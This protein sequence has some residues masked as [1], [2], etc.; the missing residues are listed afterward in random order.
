LSD[1][2]P[3]PAD[4]RLVYGPEPLQFGDVRR[5]GGDGPHALVIVLHGGAWKSTFNL[6]HAGHM[7][8]ALRDEGFAPFNV[9]DRRVGD[10]GGGWPGTFQDVLAAVDF[11]L[12]LPGIDRD[13]V[14]I[15]GHSA[16]GHLCILA[17]AELRLPVLP[18]A[19]G[20]DI[21][22]WKSEASYAF[23]SEDD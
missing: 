23:V 6:I 1:A 7:C 3:P 12:E 15:A 21:E 14:A 22:A 9:E 10:V 4:E 20:S 13:R 19:A 18:M 16:G 17:A 8:I 5:P 2:P 11:A